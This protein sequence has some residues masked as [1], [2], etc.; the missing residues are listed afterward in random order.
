MK[1]ESTLTQLELARQGVVSDKMIKAA[2]S[3]NIDPEILRQRIAEGTAIICH[4]NRHTNGTP[5]AVGKGLRTKVNANI[6][7]SKDDTS[8][9]LMLQL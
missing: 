7:T 5:L 1:T 8:Q 6:G 4:N 9:M 3:E 2:K